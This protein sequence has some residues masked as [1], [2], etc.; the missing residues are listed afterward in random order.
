MKNNVNFLKQYEYI[1]Y[2][3]FIAIFLI[4]YDVS[5]YNYLLYHTTIEL[6]TIFAGLSISLVA[7]VTMNIGKNKIF[8]LIGILYLYVSIIDY[9]HTLAYKGM[10]IFPTLT[11]NEPTQLWILGRLLQALGTFFIFYLGVDKLKNRLFFLGVTIATLVGFI[12]IVYGFFPDCFVEG[13]GLTKFKIAMEYVIVLFSVLTILKIN[14]HEKEDREHIKACFC[15]DIKFSL[16]FLIFGELSFTL[17]T[18]VYGFFNFLGHVFKFFSYYVLLRGITVR[19]LIDPV[20]TILA[21]LSSKNEE[22]QRIAYY[23]KLTKLYSRSFFEEIKDKHLNMLDRTRQK[24]VLILLDINNFK[25]INDTYG[26]DVGDKVLKFVGETISK[27]V[28]ASDIAARFGGDE[29]IIILPHSQAFD[30]AIAAERIRN[31]IISERPFQFLVDISY[32][33]GE[34]SSSEEYELAFKNAD[35]FLY[36]MKKHKNSLRKEDKNWKA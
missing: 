11:A 12:A 18:D 24:S 8:I 22:L 15:K 16:Y 7:L 2:L 31:H 17:Y 3:S 9:V 28:R 5:L 26:H 29:F 25:D 35:T 6:F 10:N 19:S 1:I 21:D 27:N 30:A 14:K 20:N 4:L 23:D 33:I 36:E 32:G 13:K 34:F